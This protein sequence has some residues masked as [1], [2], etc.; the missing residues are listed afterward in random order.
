MGYIMDLREIV[1]SRP[2]IMAGACLL[3]ID[4]QD[5]ILLQLRTDNGKWGLPGGSLEPGETMEAVA[6]RELFEEIGLVAGN[7]QLFDIFSGEEFYYKYPHGDEVFNVIAAYICR[8]YQG[9]LH[10][11]ESEVKEVKFFEISDL[12]ESINPPDKP[13]I[14]RYIYGGA[15]RQPVDRDSL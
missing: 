13:I 12:P 11:D 10:L 6:K 5:R 7:L 1:G 3:V 2:L 15:V 9:E 14:K 8:E 4:P